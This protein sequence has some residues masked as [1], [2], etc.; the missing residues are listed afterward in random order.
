MKLR[1]QINDAKDFET[2]AYAIVEY[3]AEVGHARSDKGVVSI[4]RFEE[5]LET[6]YD[7]QNHL[8][9]FRGTDPDNVLVLKFETVFTRETQEHLN[10]FEMSFKSDYMRDIV[11]VMF[12]VME[13]D[14]GILEVT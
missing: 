8:L 5:D 6:R 1:D 2:V 9:A 14:C 12:D 4:R 3:V 7:D 13:R 11:T 10:A